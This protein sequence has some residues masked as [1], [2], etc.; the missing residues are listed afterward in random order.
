MVDRLYGYQSKINMIVVNQ[1]SNSD[2]RNSAWKR[3]VAVYRLRR[4]G[5]GYRMELVVKPESVESGT[6]RFV[7]MEVEH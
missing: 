3:D 4:N 5:A 7:V 2:L 1:L 6:R